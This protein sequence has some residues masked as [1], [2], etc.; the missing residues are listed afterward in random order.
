MTTFLNFFLGTASEKLHGKALLS[1]FYWTILYY[2]I[3]SRIYSVE[4][5]QTTFA[6]PCEVQLL[7]PRM[8]NLIMDLN[9]IKAWSL[10]TWA[11]TNSIQVCL[12]H[13]GGMHASWMWMRQATSLHGSASYIQVHSAASAGR[14][15]RERRASLSHHTANS[16]Q[17]CAQ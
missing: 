12:Q 2:N 11:H 17:V 13:K 3:L 10:F 5:I 14:F 8:I 4:D 15:S 9:T 6:T 1:I 16:P 7:Q